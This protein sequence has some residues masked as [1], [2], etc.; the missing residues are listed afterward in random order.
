MDTQLIAK[1]LPTK[2]DGKRSIGTGY[3]ISKDLV[4]T[5]RH[6]VIFT[7]RDD[8]IPI[9]IEWP[10]LKE[11]QGLL[12]KTEVTE[13]VYE[14]EQYDIAVLKC[15]VPPQ[16][17]I[18]P[19]LLSR[20]FPVEHELWVTFG[21]PRLG[22]DENAHTREKI[23]ALGRFH[24][25]DTDNHKISLTSESD[26]VEKSGW[27][28]IS[29]APVFQSTDLYAVIIETPENRGE[30]FTAVSI[31]YLLKHDQLFFKIVGLDRLELGFSSAIAYLHNHSQPMQQA[32]LIQIGKISKEVESSPQ[33]IIRYLV[34][35]PIPKLIGI[36]HET[37][38][39]TPSIR[40][41][42]RQLI[43]LLLPSLYD[44]DC[45]SQIR[46]SKGNGSV[47][48][49]KIPYAT[50]VSAEILMASADKRPTDFKVIDLGNRKQLRA[51]NY[52]LPH[53][54]EAG[55]DNGRQ[56]HKDRL[57]DLCSRFADRKTADNIPCE[58]DAHLFARIASQQQ[59]DYSDNDKKILLQRTLM[60]DAK[61][62][63]PSY[64]WLWNT[65]KKEDKLEAEYLQKLVEELK[66]DYPQ[67]VFLSLEHNVQ[68]VA[69]EED[70]FVLLVDI[71]A[72]D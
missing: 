50:D 30:C 28:G 23:S 65:P 48:V 64:Y 37:Q 41:T 61:V 11:D 45:V 4:L 16:A 54:P 13:I 44:F 40:Q 7:A 35:L 8:K 47:K 14:S 66:T 5:A 17:H 46:A 36:I 1:V 72:T 39:T 9:S 49:L 63:R 32:L 34:N 26:A 67:I 43:S 31:P 56:Q 24:P 52:R 25:P 22:K 59:Q 20:R 62:K 42:L 12:C 19:L 29:G 53:P 71:Y 68:K 51:K 6:V 10:D 70:L 57:D 15:R 38:Q 3:P 69:D 55:P 60:R 58:I 33:A 2:K 21:Y 18:S 27:C